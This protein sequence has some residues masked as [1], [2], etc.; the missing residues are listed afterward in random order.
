MNHNVLRELKQ[1]L[2]DCL[3][4]MEAYSECVFLDYPDYLNLGD[5]LIWLGSIFYLRNTLNLKINYCASKENF[6]DLE[7]ETKSN[8]SPIFFNGGGNLGD[9]WSEFQEFREYIIEKYKD[10]PIVILPQSIYFKNPDNLHKTAKIFNSHPNLTIFVRDNYSYQIASTFFDN[11]QVFKAPDLALEMINSLNLPSKKQEE[12]NSILYLCRKDQELN[13]DFN[14]NKFNRSNLVVEDW[15]SFNWKLGVEKGK[16]GRLL[17]TIY[18]EGWQRG[19]QTPKEWLT[20]QKWLAFNPQTKILQNTDYANLHLNSWSFVHS[21]INQFNQHQLI[22][23][24]RL[25]GHILGILLEKPH[26]FLPNSYHKNEQ[27]YQTWTSDLPFCR[28]VKDADQIPLMV[29]EL[30]EFYDY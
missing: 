10:R 7:M 11:C 12:S 16:M 13:P 24:N 22:I 18:R 2:H 1:S 3:R 4:P 6:S 29:S 23:T 25:H 30:L 15:P 5:H 8:Q 27:F 14:L 26:I 19:L 17:A 9:L 21:A 20:R 28:F